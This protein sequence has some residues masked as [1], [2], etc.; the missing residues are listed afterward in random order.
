MSE[1]IY[2]HSYDANSVMQPSGRTLYQLE[3]ANNIYL[4]IGNK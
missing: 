3:A 1:T 4:I 2:K